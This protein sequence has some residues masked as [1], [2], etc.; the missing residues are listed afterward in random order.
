MKPIAPNT[1]IQNRYLIIHLIGKGG[2][3]EVYLAVD[4]RLGSAIALKRTFFSDD[5]T[6][7]NAF[8]REAKTLARLRHPV[9][10]KVSDHF[11][12]E[13]TQY[14]VMEHISG[15][16]MSK[17]LEINQKPFPLTWVLFWADQLLDAL[18]YL[19]THEPPIIH[20]DIKPQNLKLTDENHIVLLDFGLSKNTIGETRITTTGSIVGY[21][22]HYAPMEQIRGTGTDA[23]SDLYSLSATLYQILTNT[24]PP[25]ALTRADSLINGLPDP[26][27]PID[28]LNSE[29]SKMVSGVIIKGMAISQ[30]QRYKTAREMQK[31]LRDAYAQLQNDMSANTVA[32]SSQN[33]SEIPQS[34]Q[35]TAVISHIPSIS[36][37]PSESPT[38]P[39]SANSVKILNNTADLPTEP[40]NAQVSEPDFETTLRYDKDVDEASAKQSGIKTEVFLA[41]SSIVSP[42]PKEEVEHADV[43]PKIE[44]IHTDD[45]FSE[46][47]NFSFDNNFEKTTNFSPEA[48]VPL[49]SL[50]NQ[51][52]NNGQA[53]STEMF[54]STYKQNSNVNSAEKIF[55]PTDNFSPNKE[56]AATKPVL[57]PK[58]SSGK[59]L[60]IGG[61]LV[62]LFILAIG[63]AGFGW[64]MLRDK[65]KAVENLTPT[66][67]P[68]ASVSIEP[69]VAPTL[70][71]ASD[72]NTSTNSEITTSD[73]NNSTNSEVIN[74]EAND[75]TVEN[76][77]IIST[78]PVK[79]TQKP[80]P[81]PVK[82]ATPRTTQQTVTVKTPPPVKTPPA[83]TSKV[84]RTDILQ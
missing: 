67:M 73:A 3:G 33:Q 66:P 50:D 49:F 84:K 11:T 62:A 56:V 19:H 13:G 79:S 15:E 17:R 9:L 47:E 26:V 48:T 81:L 69:T 68:E 63:A 31:A 78:N 24:I 20:R 29:V 6:L 36:Q 75:S 22:P 21:T 83:N 71:I 51:P 43:S 54:D 76:E 30:E 45:D 52:D 23:R 77:P 10:P 70:E 39:K 65:G 53:Q 14:L 57:T 1:L 38:V 2:M 55:V 40:I 34:Q 82:T 60:A 35:K 42:A 61:G 16:D 44:D 4:Q 41:D 64:F 32:F 8:E 37:L 74:S 12:D 58:K 72:A 7:G 80:P 59:A 46:S 27:K 18:T 28:E 25:D 5:A